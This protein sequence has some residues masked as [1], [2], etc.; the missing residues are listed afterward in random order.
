V[1]DVIPTQRKS[2]ALD[3]LELVRGVLV[4]VE[5]EIADGEYAKAHES[6]RYL[7]ALAGQLAYFIGVEHGVKP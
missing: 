5:R 4:Q 6:A 3:R 1:A 2:W 7:K